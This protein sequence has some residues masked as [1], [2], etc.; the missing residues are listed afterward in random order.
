MRDAAAARNRG[1]ARMDANNR[2]IQRSHWL[3][4]DRRVFRA[5]RLAPVAA[6][7]AAAIALLYATE[8]GLLAISLALLTWVFFNLVWI[9]V[10]RRPAVA[11][12]LSLIL[13]EALIVL[14]EF[15]FNT[16]SITIS[17]LDFLIVDADTV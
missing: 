12:A 5:L 2:W 13:L 14:S 15:K 1:R 6:L 4:I 16:I 8:E 11:A 9:A 7:H 10:L 17:F 3:H